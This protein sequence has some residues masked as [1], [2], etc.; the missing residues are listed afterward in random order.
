MD[1]QS[2]LQKA[3]ELQT[4]LIDHINGDV[5]YAN[6]SEI[7][8]TLLLSARTRPRLPDFVRHCRT[9][10]AF[11]DFITS[12]IPDDHSN[13]NVSK[14]RRA[15]V[16][17]AFEPLLDALERELIS[18]ADFEITG[19]LQRLDSDAIL[20]VWQKALDRRSTDPGGA[21]TTAR[22]LVESVCK[23]ILKDLDKPYR[24]DADLPKLYHKAAEELNL[25][26]GQ[27]SEDIFRRILGSAQQVVEGLGA[28]RNA[29]SDAH[30]SSARSYEPAKR[31]AELAVNL[32]GSVA[33]FLVKS[34]LEKHCED[35]KTASNQDGSG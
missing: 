18:P 34:Y 23:H 32:A 33:A 30:G 8:R 27:H 7:R 25:S 3:E 35:E 11:E 19:E 28:V 15:F 1:V 22:T 5:V 29:H 17:E 26:P 10:D 21:I 4:G 24:E 2:L 6:Y 13:P 14:Q 20:G 9:L 16:R 31:H 12:K